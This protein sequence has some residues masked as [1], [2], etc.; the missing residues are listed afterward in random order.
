MFKHLYELSKSGKITEMKDW[1]ERN[2]NKG[3]HDDLLKRAED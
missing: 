1:L 3:D 2:S